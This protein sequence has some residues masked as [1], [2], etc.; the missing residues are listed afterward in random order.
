M[1]EATYVVGQ[2]CHLAYG[3]GEFKVHDLENIG[4]TELV[5]TTVGFPGSANSPLP[6]PVQAADAPQ[7]A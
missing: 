5:F 6:L 3:S 2:T 4:D 7:I 1:V